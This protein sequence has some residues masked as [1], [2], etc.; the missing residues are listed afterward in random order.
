MFATKVLLPPEKII[1]KLPALLILI[2]G[3]LICS[4]NKPAHAIVRGKP[5]H[6]LALYGEPKYGPDFEHFEYVNPNAPKGGTLTRGLIGTFDSFNAF[7]FKPNLPSS[8]RIEFR[9]S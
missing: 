8:K 3:L 7:S 2:M 1:L 6:G 4:I 5:V 9:I